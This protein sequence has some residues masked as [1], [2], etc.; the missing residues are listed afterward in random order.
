MDDWQLDASGRV[1]HLRVLWQR[2][3]TSALVVHV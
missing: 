2:R 1:E 3:M